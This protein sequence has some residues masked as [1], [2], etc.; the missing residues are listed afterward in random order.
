MEQKKAWEG[1]KL[2]FFVAI[3]G[4]VASH[5]A[6]QAVTET[7]LHPSDQLIV[8]HIYDEKKEFLTFDMK[9]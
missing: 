5:L 4:S 9:P 1:S 8:S 3:D 6:F 7:L 2:N